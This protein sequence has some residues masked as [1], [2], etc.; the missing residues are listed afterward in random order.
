MKTNLIVHKYNPSSAPKVSVILLDW[1]V[2]K[3]FDS[4]DWL[5]KQ[6]IPRNQYELIW[7]ETYHRV[8]P[9]VMEKADVIITCGQKGLYHK[10]VGL[11]AGILHA[12]GQIVTNCDSDA[13]YPP[14]F[15]ESIIHMFYPKK[16]IE[17]QSLI[18]MHYEWRTHETYPE[19]L[20][21]IKDLSNYSWKGGLWPNVGA[22]MSVR[23]IDAIRYG[24][25]DEHNSYR[26]YMAG[27]DLTWRL[28]NA[29]LPEI[30]HDQS[31]A[32]WHFA[33][34]QPNTVG[35]DFSLKRW[36]EIAYPHVDLMPLTAVEAF[37]SG[38]ILPLQENPEIHQ[39]RMKLRQIGSQ[40]EER[41]ATMYPLVGLSKWKYFKMYVSIVINEAIKRFMY[42]QFLIMRSLFVGILK[43]VLGS[44][45]YGTLRSLWRSIRDKK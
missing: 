11:N 39:L 34:P 33:H 36:F 40:Y 13:V 44:Q 4:L 3:R 45:R 35:A 19:S 26:G 12:R 20:S 41:F 21:D 9:E 42:S 32:L 22:C 37:S 30:W 23:K 43:K 10:H 27:A 28:I 5:S 31:V 18:L 2:R 6:N 38:R 1:S 7:V 14:N 25:W 8:I 24:G 17:P 29:G 16:T 15:I